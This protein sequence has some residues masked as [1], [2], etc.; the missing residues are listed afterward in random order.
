MPS[1][2]VCGAFDDIRSIDVRFLE[3]AAKLG[4]VHVW[5]LPDEAVKLATGRPP[6][7]PLEERTYFVQA[8]RFVHRVEIRGTGSLR[9]PEGVEKPNM[10]AI[11]EADAAVDKQKFCRDNGIP[12]HI[13]PDSQLSG[14]PEPEVDVGSAS[15]RKK[16][17]VTGCYDWL[18]TGHVRFFEEVSEYGDVYAVV[19]HDANIKL[20]KGD[21]HPQFSQHERRYMVGAIRY[22][23]RAL[24]S[25][26]DGWLDAEPEIRHIRPDIYAVNDD[27]DRP[28]KKELCE[29]NGIEYLVLNRLPKP[30]LPRRQSTVL[31]GF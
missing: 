22:I 13:I 25:T 26:G 19:G 8:I 21:G 1:V 3:E 23:K 24:V 7:F 4:H 30:G 6:K 27:G 15:D 28:E 18:H 14:F 31:R 2:I 5:L 17:L 10:W 29:K 11:R 12:C 20:L 16:V 9:I